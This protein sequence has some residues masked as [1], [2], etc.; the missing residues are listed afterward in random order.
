MQKVGRMSMSEPTVSDPTVQIAELLHSCSVRLLRHVRKADLQAPV[1]P[2]QLSILSILY[3]SDGLSLSALAA[4]EQVSQPTMSRIVASLITSGAVSKT[5]VEDDARSQ[6][7]RLTKTGRQI[8]EDARRR[9]VDAVVQILSPLSP[10]ALRLLGLSLP[11]VA[12]AIAAAPPWRPEI[13]LVDN[14][15]R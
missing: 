6:I 8:F 2:A 11:E 12:D 13:G 10:L 7:V 3:F 9:R 4:T 1:G 15:A 14:T 5:K